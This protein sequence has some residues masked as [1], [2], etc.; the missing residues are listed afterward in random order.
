MCVQGGLLVLS[1]AK[2]EG[3]RQAAPAKHAL[4]GY[5]LIQ[6]KALPGNVPAHDSH[7]PRDALH[8]LQVYERLLPRL[9]RALSQVRGDEPERHQHHSQPR[10][11]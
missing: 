10:E 3:A 7:R 9:G 6:A 4:S 5:G 8:S 11:R 1:Y 2:V